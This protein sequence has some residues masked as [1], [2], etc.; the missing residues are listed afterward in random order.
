M[1]FFSTIIFYLLLL[2]SIRGT[3]EIYVIEMEPIVVTGTRT[4]KKLSESPVHTEVISR[5]QIK[6]SGAQHIGEILN[7]Q[8]GMEVSQSTMTGSSLEMEGLGSE[9]ILVLVDGQRIAGRIAGVIDL[10]RFPTENIERIEIMRG[11][12]SALYGSDA[13]AGVI[14]IITRKAKNPLEIEVDASYGS[15]NTFDTNAAVAIQQKNFSGNITTG[16]HRRDSYDLDTSDIGMT[17]RSFD[18]FHIAENSKFIISN[19][20]NI[21]SNADYF[22]RNQAGISGTSAWPIF[23]DTKQTQTFA[24][25]IGP[26][27]EFGTDSRV[28]LLAHYSF[29]G[30]KYKQ[31]MRGS[32]LL[33]SKDKTVEQISQLTFQYDQLLWIHHLLT[34]GTELS[35]EE[36]EWGTTAN[37]RAQ[38]IGKRPYYTG[39][40]TLYAEPYTLLS[41]RITKSF[42]THLEIFT[43][44][45]NLL[46]SGDIQYAPLEPL[47]IYAGARAKY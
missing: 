32:D 36:E 3:E 34:T 24:A 39:D 38:I 13:M 19:K 12:S 23:D 11:S 17:G 33:D 16:F 8:P 37:V 41:L 6:A 40:G 5:E 1:K 14:N 7:T 20:L 43:G 2:T 28:K 22:L 35:H 47:T 46:D 15:L 31:D 27:Y 18:D 30:D 44:G 45:N 29:Y 4:N 21:Q 10:S 42:G 25:T 9:Y 26:E